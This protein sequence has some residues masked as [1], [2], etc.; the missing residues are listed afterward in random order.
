MRIANSK[1]YKIKTARPL[2]GLELLRLSRMSRQLSLYL[3]IYSLHH[4]FYPRSHC[5]YIK[6]TKNGAPNHHFMTSTFDFNLL[7]NNSST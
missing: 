7:E 1:I 3:I 6:Y 2:W 4:V 5:L